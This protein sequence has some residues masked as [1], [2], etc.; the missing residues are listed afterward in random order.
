MKCKKCNK[1]VGLV[2]WFIYNYMHKYCLKKIKEEGKINKEE[3][4]ED[5]KK[6]DREKL[7]PPFLLHVAGFFVY[8]II[9]FIINSISVGGVGVS[10]QISGI[11][12]WYLMFRMSSEMYTE[13]I[14]EKI[15][16]YISYFGAIAMFTIGF[17]VVA[18]IIG[19]VGGNLSSPQEEYIS[20]PQEEYITY[21]NEINES[22]YAG[23]LTYSDDVISIRY[24]SYLKP[25]EPNH[26]EVYKV[27]RENVNEDTLFQGNVILLFLDAEGESLTQL[28]DWSI[29]STKENEDFKLVSQEKTTMYG[30]EAIKS[31]YTWTYSVDNYKIDLKGLMLEFIVEEIYV[32]LQYTTGEIDDFDEHLDDVNKMMNSLVL[33]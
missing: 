7:K 29:D 2:E 3:L 33:G 21:S 15:N 8:L 19:Y 31:I 1:E 25:G 16:P 5:I 11:F 4:K 23:F 20:S 6:V 27:F 13:A 12:V 10:V 28:S 24:P 30:E 22:D 32:N 14:K 17:A 9:L 26:D 18:L